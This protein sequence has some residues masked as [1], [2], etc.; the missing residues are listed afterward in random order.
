MNRRS[1]DSG[2][3]LDEAASGKLL[4]YLSIY[5]SDKISQPSL[6]ELSPINQ[7]TNEKHIHTYIH[8]YI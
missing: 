3:W 6:H 2:Q 4:I 7:P 5:L 1:Y 8:A